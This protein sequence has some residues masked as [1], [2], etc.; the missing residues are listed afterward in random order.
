MQYNGLPKTYPGSLLNLVDNDEED[1]PK[2]EAN[3]TT[4]SDPKQPPAEA[5]KPAEKKR[6]SEF[7][8]WAYYLSTIGGG[9]LLAMCLLTATSVMLGGVNRKCS[10]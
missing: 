4:L 7:E 5:E 3:G 10:F 8:D 1:A 9:Y 2:N 6:H